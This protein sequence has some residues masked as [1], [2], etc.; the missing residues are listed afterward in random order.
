MDGKKEKSASYS[1]NQMVGHLNTST[2][3]GNVLPDVVEIGC[4]LWR[5]A[6]RHQ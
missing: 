3:F 1:I 6:V 5:D 4:G 2:L